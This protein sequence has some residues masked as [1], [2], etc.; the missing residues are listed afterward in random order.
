VARSL[1]RVCPAGGKASAGAGASPGPSVPD[2]DRPSRA[3]VMRALKLSP[4]PSMQ[5]AYTFGHAVP[6]PPS[7]VGGR[8]PGVQPQRCGTV[9]KVEG[10]SRERRGVLLRGQSV[11]SRLLPRRRAARCRLETHDELAW[12]RQG[13]PGVGARSS[14]LPRGPMRPT[15]PRASCRASAGV[16]T[17]TP[18]APVRA[19]RPFPSTSAAHEHAS[20]G[21]SSGSR[22]GQPIPSPTTRAR[23]ERTAAHRAGRR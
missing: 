16:Q 9:T 14:G 17:A 11:P 5:L 6:E 21:G 18:A 19:C 7:H 3:A 1:S 13:S 12:G 10:P 2:R 15:G 23:P 8:N 22:M 20:G 4:S